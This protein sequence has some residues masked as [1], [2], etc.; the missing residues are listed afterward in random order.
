VREHTF[1]PVRVIEASNT[2]P[3]ALGGF[4]ISSSI[5]ATNHTRSIY[6]SLDFLGDVGGLF[7]M[8]RLVTQV[9]IQLLFTISGSGLDA[10][11]L[12]AIF[13]ESKGHHKSEISE[14]QARKPITV[15]WSLCCFSRRTKRYRMLQKGLH[16]IEKEQDFVGFVKKQMKLDTALKVLFSTTE[17]FLLANQVQFVLNY[18]SPNTEKQE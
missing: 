9:F 8:L 11:L 12:K 13:K 5:D 4:I 14:I 7:D 18:S 10:F 16:R 2:A 3:D 6:S 1:Y 17:R 15:G